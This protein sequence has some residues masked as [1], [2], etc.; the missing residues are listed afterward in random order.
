[1]V[2]HKETLLELCTK[3]TTQGNSISVRMLEYLSTVKSLP[4]GFKELAADF[5]DLS[6]ILWSIE[7]GLSEAAQKKQRFPN[8]MVSELEAKFRKTIDDFS[9]LNQMILKFLEYEN[10]G[11]LGKF[12]KGWRLMFSGTDIDKVRQSLLKDKE[13][14]RMS[15]LVFKWSLGDAKV[16]SNIGI[17][18]TGLL[19]A[20]ER[21]NV[22]QPTTVIP[23]LSVPSSGETLIDGP[24]QLPLPALPST[25]RAMSEKS[26][27]IVTH[28]PRYDS[29]NNSSE[30]RRTPSSLEERRGRYDPPDLHASYSEDRRGNLNRHPT[31]SSGGTASGRSNGLRHESFATESTMMLDSYLRDST[32]DTT[33]LPSHSEP[34]YPTKFIRVKA[35]PSTVPHW[36][37]RPSGSPSPNSRVA[38]LHAIQNKDCSAVER[39]LDDGADISD[40]NLLIRACLNGDEEIVRVLLLFGA[41]TN[42]ADGN[43]YTPLYAAVK[44]SLVEAV[45]ML[46]KYGANP[47]LSAGPEEVTPL[48]V[49]SNERNFEI[50]HLLLM[51]G[52]DPAMI[53]GCGNT[54]LIAS[55]NKTVPPRIIELM[56]DYETDPNAKNR[57]GTTPL[58]VAIQTVRLDLMALLLDHG[59]NPNLPG[60]KHP[61]WP[62][63]YHAEALQLMLNRGADTNKSPGIMELA[64]SLK[65]IDSISILL[66]HGVSPN[67][68]KDGIY[69]PLCSAIRDNSVEIVDLL[70][71]NGADP[72]LP[73]SEYPHFKCITHDRVHI[74]PKLLAAGTNLNEPAGILETA[75]AHNHTEGLKWLLAQGVDP[76]ARNEDGRT[77]LTTA[78]RD[79]RVE[80]VDLLLANGADPNVRGEDW[81][82]IMAVKR[83]PV[84]KKLLKVVQKPSSVRGVI[85]QAVLANQLESIKMLL[86]AGVSVE[87]K[88]GGVFSPLT[89]ALREQNK[90]IVRFLLYEANA[91]PNAPGEH[92]PLIKAIRRCPHND[93][94]CIEM[95]LDRGADINKMYRGWNPV[96]Q[97]VETGNLK[98]LK[99]LLERGNPLDLEVTDDDGKTVRE[100]VIER[101]WAEAIPLLFPKPAS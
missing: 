84:L 53:M 44:A 40:P 95:L 81:P 2:K 68:K 45:E 92:L 7:A 8:D 65:N 89:T 75:V 18:Y 12:Q 15:S 59:A 25:E 94:E 88:T 83:P 90:E 42:A 26:Q 54:P 100:A 97:A 10:K 46:M 30:E 98:I 21:M 13:A 62:S 55:I 23:P 31:I 70:L 41:D 51:Y 93:T 38:L 47:N 71:A 58:F 86:K 57:E 66:D 22:N 72:N 78:I 35:D 37:P 43:G 61:L 29:L 79:N 77:A 99:V 34:K 9:V 67:I 24:P 85:E 19:A 32:R 33:I 101:G 39:L 64:S 87:D 1:M 60:P 50:V 6:R 5:L 28:L 82:L 52:A 14:L 49:A 27:P 96:L 76:N 73:A 20:M 63:T 74:L 4:L 17:G 56:L 11:A 3:A 16:E 91:N 36:T 69:T 48:V 80:L